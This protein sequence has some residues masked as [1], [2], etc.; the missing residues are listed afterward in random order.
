M[1]WPR[2]WGQVF[3]GLAVDT[4]M[5]DPEP[6]YLL[7]VLG[8]AVVGMIVA[9]L[10]W[11]QRDR[12][13]ASSLALFVTAASLWSMAEG[14]ELAAVGLGSMRPFAR[15]GLVLSTVIP[16]AWLVTVLAYTGHEEWLTRRRLAALLVEPLVFTTFV[17]TVSGHTLVWRQPGTVSVGTTSAFA[18]VYGLPSGAIWRIH[19]RW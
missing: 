14:L 7:L 9:F 3:A 16:L 11:L 13:G 15:A 18:P 17:V 1:G 4:P 5:L 12:P 2:S 8:T 19:W 6:V 10:L